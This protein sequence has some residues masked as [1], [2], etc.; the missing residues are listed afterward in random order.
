[1]TVPIKSTEEELQF[2]LS[3]IRTLWHFDCEFICFFF[4]FSVR[5][6]TDRFNCIFPNM[7]CCSL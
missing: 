2:A 5:N 3:F 4:F 6:R 7:S 1:M